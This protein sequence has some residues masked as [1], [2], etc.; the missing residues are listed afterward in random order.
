[1]PETT[2][3]P[4]FLQSRA[5]QVLSL[6]LILQALA[7]YGFSRRETV[8]PTRPLADFPR[9]FGQ[10]QLSQ[11]GVVDKETMDVLRA[12]DVLNRTYAGPGGQANLFVA[13]FK[14]QRAG[15]APHSPK[16]CLPGSGWVPEASGVVR[17]DVPGRPQ[18]IPVNRYLVQKGDARSLVLYWY[19]SRDRVVANEYEAKFY[20]V[21]D[22][23]RYNRTDTALVRI[24]VP[25]PEGDAGDANRLAAG[26]IREAFPL[27]R[28][29]LPQ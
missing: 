19:Q 24:V 23:I 8:P 29:A 18:P 12:D 22:A 28:E 27:L 14:S 11:E 6:L 3:R 7:L 2:R 20:V 10:W 21:A 17:L 16:N 1:M 15:Q 9:S 5:A 13:F 4:G 25:A 26:F